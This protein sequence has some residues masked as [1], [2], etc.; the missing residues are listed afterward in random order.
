MERHRKGAPLQAAE[1]LEIGIGPADGTE[2]ACRPEE[3]GVLASQR[4]RM[5]DVSR[6]TDSYGT[7]GDLLRR[8]AGG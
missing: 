1:Y 7:M 2:I 5:R 8:L 3:L 6:G 4:Y